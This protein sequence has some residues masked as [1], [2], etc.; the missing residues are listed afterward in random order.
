MFFFPLPRRTTVVKV[1]EVEVVKRTFICL[2]EQQL[3]FEECRVDYTCSPNSLLE[4]ITC[5]FTGSPQIPHTFSTL[6]KKLLP[7]NMF[8]Y[9]YVYTFI[10]FIFLSWGVKIN[11]ISPL[12]TAESVVTKRVRTIVEEMVDGK[13][14]SREEDVDVEVIKS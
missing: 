3:Q 12:C 13:V 5:A 7:T 10:Y 9:L 11:A 8:L 4:T 14:V 1:V 2:S 6:K